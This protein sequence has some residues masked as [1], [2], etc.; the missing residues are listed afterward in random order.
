MPKSY[1][2]LALYFMR[3][4]KNLGHLKK[5]LGIF[6]LGRTNRNELNKKKRAGKAYLSPRAWPS[7]RPSSLL[8]CLL[9][10]RAP[11]VLG[12]KPSTPPRRAP[13][14]KLPPE[15]PN[16]ST[17]MLDELHVHSPSSQP[18]CVSPH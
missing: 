13:S 8:P 18:L 9:P 17:S 1:E 4:H 16:H 12:G 15:P 11:K 14:L 6:F 2:W 7:R 3:P 10:P 5:C